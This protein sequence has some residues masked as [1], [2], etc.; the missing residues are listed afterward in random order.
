MFLKTS[1]IV[2]LKNYNLRSC[3]LLYDTQDSPGIQVLK[4]TKVKMELLTDVDMLANV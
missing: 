2:C 3:S 4:K 1:E